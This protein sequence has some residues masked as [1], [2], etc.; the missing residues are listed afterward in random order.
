[1]ID[2]GHLCEPTGGAPRCTIEMDEVGRT[3]EPRIL[4][5]VPPGRWT[6]RI[7]TSANWRDDPEIGDTITISRPLNV[8]VG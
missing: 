5:N 1:M 6:Y 7:G 8:S 2:Q 4:D 3:R